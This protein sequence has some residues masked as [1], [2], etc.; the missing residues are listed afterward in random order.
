MTEVQSRLGRPRSAD[1][2]RAIIEATLDLLVDEG[3][4]ALTVEAVAARAA[5]RQDDRLS[6]LGQQGR[7]HRGRPVLGE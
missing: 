4:N 5:C 6:P 1:V 2:D 7:A 3:Y